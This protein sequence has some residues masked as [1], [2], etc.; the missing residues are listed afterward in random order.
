[1]N[2]KLLFNL[3]FVCGA[4]LSKANANEITATKVSD[5]SLTFTQGE[6]HYTCKT[7][8][9]YLN[10]RYSNDGQFIIFYFPSADF[11]NPIKSGSANIL[12]AYTR[13]MKGLKI[14]IKAAPKYELIIDINKNANI[15]VTN[16]FY[17]Y[18]NGGNTIDGRLL[19][20]VY[21]Y[22]TSKPLY[23]P[24]S[25]LKSDAKY[26]YHS[27]YNGDLV[28]K[29]FDSP[30]PID[31]I[32][33]NAALKVNVIST[34]G[35]YIAPVGATCEPFSGDIWGVDKKKPISFDGLDSNGITEKC[36]GIFK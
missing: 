15:M 31:S 28:G 30:A 22:G 12:A 6:K 13:C 35:K 34:D 18:K 8:Y 33:G 1:M 21:H 14:V 24:F 23:F 20:S 17:I 36:K 9:T 16:Q 5:N 7:Q 32:Q 3:F 11:K 4:V 2:V 25:P 29:G 27:D 26:I 19:S 10:F